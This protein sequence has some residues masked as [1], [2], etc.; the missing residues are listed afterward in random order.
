MDTNTPNPKNKK[1]NEIQE[2]NEIFEKFQK[3][4]DSY[5][6]I[7]DVNYAE[8]YK[9]NEMLNHFNKRVL[10]CNKL[11]ITHPE[12]KRM[13]YE[14]ESCISSCHRKIMEVEGVV[15]KYMKDLSF[16]ELQ[17]KYLDPNNEI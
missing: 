15:A 16:K 5:D 2:L 6:K 14:E 11:C 9:N 1:T 12:I 7:Q 4:L 8:M 13:L 17:T 3:Q 10:L